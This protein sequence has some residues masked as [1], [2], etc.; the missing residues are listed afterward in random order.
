MLEHMMEIF[1][2]LENDDMPHRFPVNWNND[3]IIIIKKGSIKN[4]LF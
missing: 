3:G 1:I 4:N 2:A